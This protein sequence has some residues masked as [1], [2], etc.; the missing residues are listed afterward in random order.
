M[1]DAGQ[2]GR[3][4][5]LNLALAR[6]DES[7]EYAEANKVAMLCA[8]AGMQSGEQRREMLREAT[9]SG[10][11]GRPGVS[12]RTGKRATFK[13]TVTVILGNVMPLPRG[14]MPADMDLGPQER[15]IDASLPEGWEVVVGQAHMN[16]AVRRTAEGGARAWE[17]KGGGKGKGGKGK[18]GKMG[19]KG[20]GDRYGGGGN[21]YGGKFLS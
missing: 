7:H 4:L 14:V 16:R 3:P 9:A 8:V 20:Y 10:E 13:S 5:A 1:E 19:G 17:A 2:G 21:M 6:H 12:A 11:R 15:A 18:G